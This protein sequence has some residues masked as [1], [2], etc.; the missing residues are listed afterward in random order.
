MI[1]CIPLIH[2]DLAVTILGILGRLFIVYAMNTA[3]QLSLEVV[4]TQL[5]GQGNALATVCAQVANF[6]APQIVYSKVVDSRMPFILM[7]IGSML[8]AI[9]AFF[10]PETAGIKLPDS[11]S[12][13]EVLF[14]R[15]NILKKH[16]ATVLP[17]ESAIVVNTTTKTVA[18]KAYWG[19][20]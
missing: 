14:K 8:A 19:L 1:I 20:T 3:A 5:R 11:I 17:V 10:L 12:E 2:I 15:K 18:D 16:S 4:P 9:L 7:S 6:F 13:A